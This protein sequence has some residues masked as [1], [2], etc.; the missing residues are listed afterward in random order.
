LTAPKKPKR[1]KS[2][3]YLRVL[4]EPDVAFGPGKADLL[5]G[6][7]A[8]GSIAAAGR[9]MKMSYRRAWSL[10]EIMN[11]EFGQPLVSTMKGGRTQ[12]GAQLTGTGRKVLAL[13]RRMELCAAEAIAADLRA[14]RR[15]RKRPG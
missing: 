2:G 13:Y 15:L 4:L 14:L 12:G 7:D 8:T 9:G 5:E 1:Q 6:I 10:V 3:P 11:A